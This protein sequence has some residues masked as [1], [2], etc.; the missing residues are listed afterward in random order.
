[1]RELPNTNKGC[2][3]YTETLSNGNWYRKEVLCF[4][5]H[6]LNTQKYCYSIRLN[7]VIIKIL[8]LVHS[9]TLLTI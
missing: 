4:Y 2:N 6:Y 1:M 8:I 3:C 5:F 9:E 7:I